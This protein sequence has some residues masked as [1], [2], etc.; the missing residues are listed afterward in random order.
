MIPYADFLYFGL[1]LYVVVPAL[2]L[3][4]AGRLSWRWIALAT[5]AMLVVQYGGTLQI[6]PQ[7][8]VREIWIVAAYALFEWAV[9]LAFLRVRARTKRRWP[10]Y[11]ALGLALCPLA[12][13]KFLPLFTPSFLFGFLGIS[14]VTFRALDVIF[15]VQDRLITALPPVQFLA[16]LFFFATISSGPIDRYRR[17]DADWKHRR[18]REEFLQNLDGAVHR[19]FTGFLYKFILAALVK[20]YWMDPAANQVGLLSTLSYM[21]AYSFYLFFDFAGYSA[22]AIGVSYLFG[23][24]TPENFD[25]PFLARNI[26][27]FWNRWHITLSWW[28]RDHVYMRFVMA[29]TK[30]RWFKNK[31]VASYL[32][33]LLGFG[34]MGLWH[35]TA[36]NYILYGLYHGTLLAGHDA[37]SRWNK[38]RGLWG[39]GPLWHA[40]GVVLTFN[41]VCFGFLLF[42]GHLGSRPRSATAVTSTTI[43]PLYEGNHDSA[44]CEAIG[45]WAWDKNQPDTP[46]SVDIYDAGTLLARVPASEF[47]QDLINKGRGN[48]RHGFVYAIPS[49]LKDGGWHSIRVKF[50]QTDVDLPS[51]PKPMACMDLVS[52]DGL[53]GVHDQAD[54][55]KITGWAWDA[56]RPET[57]IEVDVYDGSALLTTLTANVPSTDLLEGGFGN[58]RHR[59]AYGTPSQVRDGRVHS[60]ALKISGT[61]IYL[62]KTP[63][64]LTCQGSPNQNSSELESSSA[65]P[66]EH[67]KVP[68]NAASR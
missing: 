32:G 47:R 37:F 24:H 68:H 42:S 14:Y 61:N 63:K 21:Y 57:P 46:I 15:C 40:A 8:A 5:L 17:F 3:G 35:G 27:D 16:Y 23:I 52:V 25:R 41:S 4:L 65:K 29:A 49:T 9:A 34:L 2:I 62:M 20:Q 22:F 38:Q 18:S 10:F 53:E 54:C 26:R 7:T 43:G 30:G 13:A 36:A 66:P 45:G 19:I 28:F 48:G 60:I 12:L 64:L 1:L 50:S 67:G 44:N 59:F 33:F 55:D 31:Y 58:G 39:D 51:T 11:A 56:N 6:E